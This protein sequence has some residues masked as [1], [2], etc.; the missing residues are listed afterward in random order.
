[1]FL[2]CRTHHVVI[3][4]NE[5]HKNGMFIYYFDGTNIVRMKGRYKNGGKV[6]RW[7]G[8]YLCYGEQKN[9]GYSIYRKGKVVKS[10]HV[11]VDF[12]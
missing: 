10:I 8:Y 1:M 7:D 2:S 12:F 6:G 4:D 9:G 5:I 3:A 11:N